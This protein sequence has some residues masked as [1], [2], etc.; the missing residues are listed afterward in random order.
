MSGVEAKARASAELTIAAQGNGKAR[1]RAQACVFAALG[2]ELA[3]ILLVVRMRN[4]Q[5]G[6]GDFARACQGYE[7]RNVIVE[8]GP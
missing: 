1:L 6:G 2:Q 4:S 7:R 8:I 5:G 3:G